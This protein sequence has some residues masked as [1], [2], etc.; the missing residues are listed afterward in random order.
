MAGYSG[1]N[2]NGIALNYGFP[3]SG[4]WINM[5]IPLSAFNADH[6][7]V[8]FF[9]NTSNSGYLEL[10]FTDSDGSVFGIK[11]PLNEYSA[12]WTHITVYSDNTS[13]WWGGNASFGIASGFSIAIS[14]S[15]TG[16]H[17]VYFDEIGIGKTGLPTSFPSTLDPNW[18]LQ[19]TGFLQRR[20]LAMATEDPLVL[21]YLKQL[22]DV[23]S[24]D[25]DLVPTYAGG[26][27]AQTFNNSLV[28][29]AFIAKDE[30]ERAERI[31]DFYQQATDSNNTA[32][33]KQNFFYNGEARGFYQQA[34]ISTSLDGGN[35]DR[36][37]GDMAWLLLACKNYEL[38]FVSS[39][40]VYLTSLI[41]DLF[42]SY[43]Q[44]A[45]V[46]G[47][48][49]S[50]WRKG[51]SYL[52]E[53]AGHQEGNID[54]YAALKLCGEDYYAHQIKIWLDNELNNKTSL[55]L[56][57]YT[58]RTL[59]F[60]ALD[61]I[62][63]NLLNV[64]EYDFR[65]RKIINV[66]GTD[67]MGFYSEPDIYTDNFWIDGT[68]HM[69]CAFT[70]Y[71][72]KQRGTF[73]A[74]QMDPLMVDQ[75]FGTDTTHGL[76]YTLNTQGYPWVDPALPVV[77]SSAW[78]IL[79]KNNCNPFLSSGFTDN[80]PSGLYPTEADQEIL[81]VYPNPFSTTATIQY[82]VPYLTPV[83]IEVYAPDGS[84]MQSL[85]NSHASDG[86]Y[87]VYWHGKSSNGLKVN[88]G[89]YFIKL[90]LGNYNVVKKLVLLPD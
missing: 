26:T 43:F 16:S 42:I 66:K 6:P 41:R 8:F 9:Y 84:F 55:P 79:A 18:N 71:G 4:G 31:L 64:P 45:D 32:I 1:L 49:R 40:Y 75:V 61:T 51:D 34:I 74:N 69:S 77:S 81:I 72:D 88:P 68:G 20:D 2:N 58:W 38:K 36:W 29:M 78:Y 86:T 57:L 11:A 22:Q 60:G 12:G 73:Y 7:I 62:Y 23:S 13:Y 47:Y 25:A 63:V 39:R 44:D 14:G 10:K 3:S 89:V 37:I 87:T 53:S 17:T 33:K 67:V 50:G 85:A 46:G 5:E 56:D 82:T 15:E 65:Y 21:A 90:S 48:V 76:P 28:A 52:H 19:G 54:C 27:E 83:Q 80:V 24:A 30:K 70:A 59:A 35:S